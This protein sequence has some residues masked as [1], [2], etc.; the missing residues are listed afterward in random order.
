MSPVEILEL[1]AKLG[2]LAKEHGIA[3]VEFDGG[4]E[5]KAVHFRHA[6]PYVAQPIK[7]K[8]PS[9]DSPPTE[10]RPRFAG[11]TAEEIRDALPNW[12]RG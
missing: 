11:R 12:G 9:T 1:L 7:P 4:R 8:E 5:V 6:S 10:P 2:P 3:S